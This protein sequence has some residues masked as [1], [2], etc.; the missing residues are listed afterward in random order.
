MRVSAIQVNAYALNILLRYE[1]LTNWQKLQAQPIAVASQNG[2]ASKAKDA[3]RLPRGRS[4]SKL[5]SH[6][7]TMDATA[8]RR[9]GSRSE[10]IAVKREPPRGKRVAWPNVFCLIR[11][12][13]RK[14]STGQAPW[15]LLAFEAKRLRTSN[16]VMC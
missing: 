13:K 3:T 2:Y 1:L 16:L 12:C 7:Q 15:H 11:S 6:D 9:G 10:V 14:D 4:R 5:H 8:R